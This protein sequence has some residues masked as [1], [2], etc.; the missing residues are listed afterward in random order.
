VA[1]KEDGT[2]GGRAPLLGLL[3]SYSLPLVLHLLLEELVE[4]PPQLGLP[5]GG[6]QGLL[7]GDLLS[8]PL[9][10]RAAESGR[11]GE[12][13]KGWEGGGSNGRV[14]VRSLSLTRA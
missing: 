1:R 8:Q 5:G 12:E 7:G 13:G 3:S 9:K 2:E 6:D 10:V 4:Q 11:S 14:V